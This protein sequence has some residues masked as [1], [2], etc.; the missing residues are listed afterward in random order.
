M[1]KQQRNRR[2]DEAEAR[3]GAPED[4]HQ[5]RFMDA[6]RRLVRVEEKRALL[7]VARKL[8]SVVE[9]TAQESRLYE[10]LKRRGEFP[11]YEGQPLTGNENAE[12][13]GMVAAYA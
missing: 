6:C 10:L 13:D 11:D 7:A 8:E 1:S 5:E 2:A 9:M 3:L 4:S 12:L